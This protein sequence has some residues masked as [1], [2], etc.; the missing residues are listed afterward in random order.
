MSQAL[1]PMLNVAIKA[2]RS[3]GAFINRAS[4]D[5]ELLKVSTKSPDDL[6]HPPVP[7]PAP[8]SL[9]AR[10]PITRRHRRRR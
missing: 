3:A 8:R 5:L 7:L 4:L 9:G 6:T 2:A 10:I 1:H